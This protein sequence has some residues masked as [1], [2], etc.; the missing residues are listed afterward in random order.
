VG[1]G[2]GQPGRLDREVISR[3][4]AYLFLA[5]GTLGLA[6]LALPHPPGQIR[7]GVFGASMLAYLGAVVLIVGY[8]RI[9]ERL[10]QAIVAIGILTISSGIYFQGQGRGAGGVLYFPIVVGVFYFFDWK[11]AVA[12]TI[13]LAI[14]Y[15]AVLL[16]QQDLKEAIQYWAPTIAM[17]CVIGFL[18][19]RVRRQ[20][21][22][23]VARLEKTA[24][25]DTLTGLLNRRGFEDRFGPELERARRGERLMGLLVGDVDH[26]KE[27][28]DR[29]GHHAGDEALTRIGK[30]LA[31]EKRQIDV[32]ARMGGE[33]FALILPDTDQ[34]GAYVMGER[35]RVAVRRAFASEPV[36]L[37]L[38]FGIA[39]FPS[40]GES[41][42]SLLRSADQALYAA[43]AL[44]RDR[45][46]IHSPEIAGTR[47]VVRAPG[48][49]GEAQ[50]GIVLALAETLDVRS[51]GSAPHSKGVGRF[52]AL[53]ARELGLPSEVAE[54]VRLAGT[55]HDIGKVGVPD[56]ILRKP[57]PLSAGE[58]SLIRKHPEIGARM[59]D[60]PGLD[61]LREW[62]LAHQ[63]RPDGKGYPRGLVGEQIPLEARILAVADAYEAMTSD[64]AYRPA[65]AAVEARRELL[66]NAGTQF[67]ATVVEAFVGLLGAEH[68]GVATPAGA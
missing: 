30:I 15:G 53:I 59:L 11:R 55:L 8:G 20:I 35:L 62:V 45:S 16:M 50:L 24:R 7:P 1:G 25:T 47:P 43:K 12:Q 2:L 65:L 29:L 19:G 33:E 18:M 67:D 66:E 44:G 48:A 5:G 58:W 21:D 17:I 38:C 61:D 46:V 13:L 52:A 32:V 42:E 56:A 22:W 6:M 64:R 37:T 14:S 10:F 28:N 4:G 9:S 40:H 26:F 54:R 3:F 23:L 57:G 68:A 31:E 49:T 60:G 39:S 51:S 36:P 41:G 34:H 27:V 63:E